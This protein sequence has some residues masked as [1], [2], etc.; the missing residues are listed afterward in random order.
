MERIEW[1]QILFSGVVTLSTAVSALLTWRLV[2]ET[3]M[4]REYYIQP[5][6]SIF[7]DCGEAD[8]GLVFVCIKNN[9]QGAAFDLI[10]RIVKDYNYYKNDKHSLNTKGLFKYGA[11]GLY[12]S[13]QYR[14]FL[15]DLSTNQ[16]EVYDDYMLFAV[17]YKNALGHK[18]EREYRLNL[19]EVVGLS[20]FTPPETYIGRISYQLKKIREILE[21]R[22]LSL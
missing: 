11:K 17:S 10:I 12:P 20:V 6:I 21:S 4:M 2:K 13:Q 9:G 22:N 1:I 19:N 18:F 14:Y 5:D 16:S 8:A 15:T 3:R 7:L